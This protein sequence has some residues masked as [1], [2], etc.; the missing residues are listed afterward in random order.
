[1]K[2]FQTISDIGSVLVG[3]REFG[4]ALTNGIGDGTTNVIILDND[5]KCLIPKY[6]DFNTS[7]EGT[8]NI[9]N[10]DCSTRVD[11]DIVTTLSGRYGVYYLDDN[12]YFLKWED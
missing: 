10:Y 3:T 12:V 11:A 5:Q 8:F 1:M 9:Y 6:A 4:V 7:I 2:T